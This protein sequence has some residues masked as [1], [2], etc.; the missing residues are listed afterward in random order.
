MR[1]VSIVRLVVTKVGPNRVERSEFVGR[2]HANVDRDGPG[3]PHLARSRRGP[4]EPCAEN[5]NR[6]KTANAT[7]AAH[8]TSV[9]FG[10]GALRH[11]MLARSRQTR[12][13]I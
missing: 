10:E 8:S 6:I 2:V 9:V 7:G 13:S 1:R 12:P 11:R 5:R 3:R 4:K